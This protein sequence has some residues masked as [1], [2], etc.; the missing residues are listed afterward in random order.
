VLTLCA[1]TLGACDA[2]VYGADTPPGQGPAY[3]LG[4]AAPVVPSVPL[5]RSGKV[6]P[7]C[8]ADMIAAGPRFPELAL[9]G[10]PASR[11]SQG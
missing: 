11:A 6:G 9:P 8:R 7:R 5:R 4:Y 3:P 2:M 1:V 10:G